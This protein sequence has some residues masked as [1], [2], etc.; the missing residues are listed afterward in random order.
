MEK[1]QCESCFSADT[2]LRCHKC[3]NPSCKK[4]SCF[5]DEEEF[6]FL[7]L[8]PED[9]AG[10]TFCPSCYNS[11]IAATLEE[12]REYLAKARAVDVYDKEQKRESWRFRRTEKKLSIKDCDDRE[13]TLLRLALLSAQKGFDTMVDVDIQSEK[14]GTGT[15]KKLIWSGTASPV[16]SKNKK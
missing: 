16:D 2:V 7:S 13:E 11:S 8:L 5:I 3:S 10:Q 9:V 14:V 15:Y 6:D 4:C 12:Y 1:A